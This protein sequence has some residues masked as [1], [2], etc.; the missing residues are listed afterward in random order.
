MHR[1]QIL[2]CAPVPNSLY[3]PKKPRQGLDLRVEEEELEAEVRKGRCSRCPD[4]TLGK[5]NRA[6]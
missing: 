6:G 1:K 2:L 3:F 4:N 5:V